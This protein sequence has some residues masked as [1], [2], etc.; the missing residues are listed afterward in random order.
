MVAILWSSSAAGKYVETS[1]KSRRLDLRLELLV[2]V[3][4]RLPAREVVTLLGPLVPFLVLE[5][6]DRIAAAAAA[7]RRGRCC[8]FLRAAEELVQADEASVR[9]EDE[10]DDLQSRRG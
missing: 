5:R 8:F 6:R 10:D 4:R 2:L 7:A 9:A 3:E 1:G